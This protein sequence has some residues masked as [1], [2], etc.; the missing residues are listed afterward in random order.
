VLI[1]YPF[2]K[3]LA[4]RSFHMLANLAIRLGNRRDITN[5]LKLMRGDLARQLVITEPWFAANAEIGLQVVLLG[6]SIQEVPISWMNRT[7]DMGHSSFKVLK[8]GTGYVRVLW[9][10]ARGTRFGHRPL[11]KTAPV[12]A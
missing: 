4:N 5:N 1:N 12:R 11:S 7:F 9:R 3:I 10:F 8:F 2:G 6:C